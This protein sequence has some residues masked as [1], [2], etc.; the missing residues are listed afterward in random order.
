[1][2]HTREAINS[3]ALGC[4]QLLNR[5]IG[6]SDDQIDWA[7]AAQDAGDLDDA[8]HSILA[9]IEEAGEPEPKTSVEVEPSVERA[10]KPYD[11]YWRQE[12]D[13]NRDYDNGR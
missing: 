13:F 5:I 8:V 2:N 6:M 7:V 9:G 11:P 3:A 1:M 4:A 10:P 12:R